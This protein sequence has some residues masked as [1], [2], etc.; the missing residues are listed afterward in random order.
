[1]FM[2]MEMQKNVTSSTLHAKDNLTEY[3][4]A[5]FESISQS[6]S[7]Y[8]LTLFEKDVILTFGAEV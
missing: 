8:I 7:Q 4:L 6:I 5:L 1:M 3:I 2:L